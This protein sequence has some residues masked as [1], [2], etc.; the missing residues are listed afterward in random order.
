MA[1][2]GSLTLLR[3][4]TFSELFALGVLRRDDLVVT[5]RILQNFDRF[6]DFR[7]QVAVVACHALYIVIAY[8][9]LIPDQFFDFLFECLQVGLFIIPDFLFDRVQLPFDPV[10]V[11]VALR[12]LA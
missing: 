6:E 12:F 10:E 4:W 11:F 1:C 8:H 9:D 7:I 3:S 2:A 5:G